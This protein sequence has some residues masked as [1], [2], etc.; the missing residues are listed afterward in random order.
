MGQF[1]S[2]QNNERGLFIPSKLEFVD[3]SPLPTLFDSIIINFFIFKKLFL[4]LIHQNN[5]KIFLK[6]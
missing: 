4:I 5:L 2:N 3:L 6:F 1:L